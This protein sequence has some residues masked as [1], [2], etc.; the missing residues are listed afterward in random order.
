MKRICIALGAMVVLC[1][2]ASQAQASIPAPDGTITACYV[3]RVGSLRVIDYPAQQCLPNLEVRLTWNI[4]GPQGPEGPQG[5][6]GDPGPQGPPG[7]SAPTFVFCGLSTTLHTG[8]MAGLGPIRTECQ[9]TCGNPAA[10]M[11]H[12]ED[13]LVSLEKHLIPVED[14]E[15]SDV[16]AWYAS[17]I[18]PGDTA[19][20]DCLEWESESAAAIGSMWYANPILSIPFFSSCAEAHQI[21]CCA[22]ESN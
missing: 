18:S 2:I 9:A 8:M 22:P 7:A 14:E 3:K 16:H 21:A 6:Q 12:A 1:A 10:R 5:P 15:G 20:N 19:I 17:G 11:C 13:M 4:S